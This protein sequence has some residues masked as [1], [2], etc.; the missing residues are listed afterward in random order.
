MGLF[1]RKKVDGEVDAD[2]PINDTTTSGTTNGNTGIS[3]FGRSRKTTD[4]PASR[5]TTAGAL[6]LKAMRLVQLL[7]AILILGLTT[8]AV[9]IYQATFVSCYLNVDGVWT[10]QLTQCYNCNQHTYPH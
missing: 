3:R 1:V 10:T 6:P 9:D 8:Y 2:A 4:E 7:L 5:S